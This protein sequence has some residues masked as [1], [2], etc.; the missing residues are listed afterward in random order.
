MQRNSNSAAH[1]DRA[2][3]LEL[4][5]LRALCTLAVASAA[6]RS[7]M[8]SLERH[9]WRDP[10]HRIVYDAL[11]RIHPGRPTALREELPGMA[12]RMGF[13]DV[14]WALYFAPTKLKPAEFEA[15]IRAVM[16]AP[17]THAPR[18]ESAGER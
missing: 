6:L 14:D 13:P 10:E 4:E 9:I 3:D 17:A 8:V 2:R 5:I 12:T 16:Q 15:A 7:A 11:R 18:P 1:G